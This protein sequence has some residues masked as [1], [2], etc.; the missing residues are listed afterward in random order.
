MNYH[1]CMFY[2]PYPYPYPYYFYNLYYPPFSFNERQSLKTAMKIRNN[3]EQ[4][5][6]PLLSFLINSP[7]YIVKLAIYIT[8]GA[9]V[10]Y[11]RIKS[12]IRGAERIWRTLILSPPEYGTYDVKYIYGNEV[13]F[14]DK[15]FEQEGSKPKKL[16]DLFTKYRG[17]D[18]T[19][20]AVYYIGADNLIAPTIGRSYYTIKSGDQQI[21]ANIVMGNKAKYSEYAFAHELGHCLFARFQ[22]GKL[23]S[24][25]PLSNAAHNSDDKNVMFSPVPNP[26]KIPAESVQLTK[27][28]QSH[29]TKLIEHPP[30]LGGPAAYYMAHNVPPLYPTAYSLTSSD[31]VEIL[32]SDPS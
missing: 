24:L 11:E 28:Y 18:S 29:L 9:D 3:Q 16:N 30:L 17:A 25:D 14:T 2:A 20:I 27:A 32:G 31:K 21:S 13:T 1:Y 4:E 5:F 19:V 26:P 15:D 7:T 10:S 12:D 6:R 23:N 8:P 22:G